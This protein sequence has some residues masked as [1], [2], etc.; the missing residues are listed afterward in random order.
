MG[1]PIVTLAGDR[2]VGRVGASIL[3][4]LELSDWIAGTPDGYV[5]IAIEFARDHERLAQLRAKLR[6]RMKHSLLMRS[7]AFTA[8]IEEI[9][10]TFWRD[11]CHKSF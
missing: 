5:E 1:V 4:N 8:N 3:S 9:Y 11:F 2:H 10:R 6:G 7:H